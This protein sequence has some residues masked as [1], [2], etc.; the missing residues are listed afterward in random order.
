MGLTPKERD[1]IVHRVKQFRW[2]GNSLLRVWI[3]GYSSSTTTRTT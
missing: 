3:D 1:Q 2:E